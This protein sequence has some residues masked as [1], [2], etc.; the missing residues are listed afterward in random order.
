M[1]DFWRQLPWGVMIVGGVLLSLYIANLCYDMAPNRQ[2]IVRKIG[3]IGGYV[4]YLLCALVFTSWLWPFALSVGFLV[5]LSFMRFWKGTVP[6][7]G[8]ARTTTWAELWYPVSSAICIATLWGIY[9]KPFLVVFCISLLG[10]SDAVTG[11]VRSRYCTTAQKHWSGSL[12]FFVSALLSSWVFVNPI[13]FGVVISA[14]ATFIEWASG[15]VSKIPFM[16]KIDDNL[17]VPIVAMVIVVAC[18]G[19]VR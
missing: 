17:S 16:R 7:R 11:L 2:W 15:D 5:L 1:S 18:I 19:I 14:C 3:H 13:W 10:V 9:D 12:A 8:V 6:F 4:G